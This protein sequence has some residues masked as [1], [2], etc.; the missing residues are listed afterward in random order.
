VEADQPEPL[1]REVVGDTEPWRRGRLFLVL[2]AIWSCLTQALLIGSQLLAGRVDVMLVVA[3]SALLWWLMFYFIW[4]GVHWV[5][6]LNA[7]LA[8]LLAFANLIWGIVYGNPLRLIDG[9]I[10]LPIAAYLGLAPSVYFF[11]LR[12]KETVRWKESLAVGAVFALLLVSFGTAIFTLGTY[13][14]HLQRRAHEFADRSFQRLFVEGD[15]E[16]LKN[17]VTARLMQEE[18]W[19]RLSWFMADRYLRVGNA[20]DLRPA[21]GDLQFW[22]GFPVAV[23]AHGRMSTEAVG[24]EGPVRLH[25]QV[26]QVGGEWQIDSIWWRYTYGS[27]PPGR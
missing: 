16:F 17:N 10:G 9:V 26:V 20:Q 5:R 7:G 2:L 12:Q 21:R 4:I 27:P 22:Y 24:Q 1:W 14:A 18:G 11:A 25:I 13:K 3:V 8:G 23:V 6:W 15:A 19:D